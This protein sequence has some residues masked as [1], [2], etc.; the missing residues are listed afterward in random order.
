MRVLLA[1]DD[2]RVRQSIADS[3]LERD[4]DVLMACDGEDTIRM[5]RSGLPDVLVLD[6]VMPRLD[7]LAV[8]SLLPRL[9]L[10]RQPRV[11]A[12]SPFGDARIARRAREMGAVQVLPKPVELNRLLCAL[13]AR[14][15]EGCQPQVRRHITRLLSTAGIPLYTKGGTYLIEAIA[16][17]V[18]DYALIE[19]MR[20]SIYLPI[21][22][23]YDT[24]PENVERLVRHAI[25]SACTRGE[26]KTMHRL[27][28][29]TVRRDTGKPTN[30][31]FI[32]ILAE[33]IRFSM[34]AQS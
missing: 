19:R 11:L 16:M 27:F 30:A 4:V 9:G 20:E 12:L 25:E 10:E 34:R 24:R 23:K 8:L 13:S 2:G 6:M 5:L 17:T 1:E 32:A 33:N 3:L 31:E 22:Q 15:Q 7:G 21:A 14:D 29:Y 26:L 18:R 28:G